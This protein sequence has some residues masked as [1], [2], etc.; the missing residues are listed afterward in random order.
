MKRLPEKYAE[1]MKILLGDEFENYVNSFNDKPVRA[2]R[3]NTDKISVE[4][5]LKINPF[6]TKKI[7]YVENGFYFE[8]EKI[9]NH[10]YHHAGMIYV[11]EPGAMMPAE[12][13]DIE[14]DWRV[15]D[16]CAAPGGKS[17]QLKNKLGEKGILVSNEIVAS[18]CK[19]LTGNIERLGLK[20]VVTTCMDTKKLARIFPETFDLVM[21]DAPC[22]GEGM[23]RKEEVAIDE[24]SPE[25]VEN[26]TVRQAEILENAV[27][28]LK[29]G[30]YIIYATCTFS[31]DENEKTVDEFLQNHPDFELVRVKKSV[32]KNTCDGISFEG[33]VSKNINYTRRFYPHKNKGE[34]Q[35]AAV[36]RNTVSSR[37]STPFR[38]NNKGKIDKAV[39]DFL[40]STLKGYEKE[41]VLMHKETPVYFTP[42]FSVDKATAFACGVTIGEIRKNYILPHH[43]FFSAMGD[44]FKRKINLAPESDEL[45]KYLHGEEFETDCENGWAVVCVDGCTLGG[46]KVV[47][48]RAKNHYPKGLRMK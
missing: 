9:G 28:V 22:S 17:T 25:N 3:V 16:M 11:Q 5:F 35:F 21:V 4:D 38:C 23:F 42:D 27:K 1:R 2:F 44:D 40:D 18:R 14:P 39:Y 24:W 31:L 34:G 46:V 48:G 12:C 47:N 13:I 29:D 36:L 8:D 32:E 15:L 45:K 20:N 43:Q 6:T 7:P 10:P 30:G 41:K 37:K 26:C 33:C 19:I